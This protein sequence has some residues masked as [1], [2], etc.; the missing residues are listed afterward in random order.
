MK[1]VNSREFF[2][3]EDFLPVYGFLQTYFRMV[4]NIEDYFTFD[5]DDIDADFRYGYRD[6][7][8]AQFKQDY[9]NKSFNHEDQ[10]KREDGLR[11]RIKVCL[12]YVVNMGYPISENVYDYK[13]NDGGLGYFF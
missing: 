6:V 9:Y 10:D 2:E 5:D 12:K 13:Y 1:V 4:T 11:K 8:I 3:S 7:M